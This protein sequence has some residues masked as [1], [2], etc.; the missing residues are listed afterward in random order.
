MGQPVVLFLFNYQLKLKFPDLAFF[1]VAKAHKNSH[2]KKRHPSSNQNSLGR[3]SCDAKIKLQG[4]LIMFI[5][6]LDL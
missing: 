3:T 1:V 5:V 4:A 6:I 2:E